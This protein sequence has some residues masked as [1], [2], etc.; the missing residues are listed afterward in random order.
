MGSGKTEAALAVTEGFASKSKRLA[1]LFA[2]PTQAASD[3][4]F[5]RVEEIE[6]HFALFEGSV[7]VGSDEEGGE[8]V[9]RWFEGQK[10]AMLSD[11]VFGAADHLLMSAPK[12]INK[13]ITKSEF[14][15]V[16]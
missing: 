1:V 11:F 5:S 3:D 8:M 14:Y 6:R 7:N 2:L 16:Q 10:K 12:R 15:I 13:K 9:H 4:I